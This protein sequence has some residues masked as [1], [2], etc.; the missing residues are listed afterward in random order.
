MNFKPNDIVYWKFNNGD[1]AICTVLAILSDGR[2]R[3]RWHKDNFINI[4]PMSGFIKKE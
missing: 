1:H 3:V 4:M 2:L